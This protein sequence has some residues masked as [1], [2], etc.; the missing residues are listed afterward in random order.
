MEKQ[1]KMTVT[2]AYRSVA[3][4]IERAQAL[5]AMISAHAAIHSRL[6][7]KPGRQIKVAA[8]LAAE[9]LGGLT[10]EMGILGF[11]AATWEDRKKE[12]EEKQN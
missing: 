10:E 2:E 5:C 8:D 4:T 6:D 7:D 12:G 9:M 1:G 3:K 11:M